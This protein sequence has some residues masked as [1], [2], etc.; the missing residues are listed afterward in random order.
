[1]PTIFE[2]GSRGLSNLVRMYLCVDWEK[3]CAPELKV[4]RHTI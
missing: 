1:M 3:E 4:R 2:D